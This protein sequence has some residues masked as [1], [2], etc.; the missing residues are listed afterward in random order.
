MELERLV[1]QFPAYE[2]V[3]A[4]LQENPLADAVVVDIDNPERAAEIASS[5]A[6]IDSVD[7]VVYGTLAAERLASFARGL[8]T[9]SLAGTV[10]MVVVISLVV[11]SVVGLTIEYRAAEIE[12]ASLVGATKWFIMWPFILEGAILAL[13][14]W[15]AGAS[16]VV[17]LY[18]PVV[19]F[20]QRMMPFA[21][22]AIVEG[23]V[24]GSSA[25][26]GHLIRVVRDRHIRRLEAVDHRRAEGMIELDPRTTPSQA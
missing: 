21:S 10:F 17:A 14:L 12:V 26:A 2:E 19:R 25:A 13:M 7:E 24:C 1:H 4:S 16:A 9:L 3:I 20:F 8:R 22:F 18:L 15:A 11:G 23:R 6:R 5:I